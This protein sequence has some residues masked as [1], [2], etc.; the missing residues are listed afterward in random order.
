MRIGN[1]AAAQTQLDIYG[2]LLQA[3]FVYAEAGGRLDAETGRRLAATADLVCRLWR[4]RDSG[5]WEVRSG[6]DHFTHSKMMCWVALDR[7]L[8]LARPGTSRAPR[9]G[10]AP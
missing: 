8:R 7:A 4:E 5:I 10:L 1:A 3:A 6:P 9:I 2:D